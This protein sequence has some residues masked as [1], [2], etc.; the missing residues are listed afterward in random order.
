MSRWSRLSRAPLEKL[1]AYQRRMGWE[2]K[3]LSSLGSDFNWDYF[4]SFTPEQQQQQEMYYNYRLGVFPATECPGI[5][6]FFKDENGDVFH[7][8]SAYARGLETFLGIYNLLDIVPNGRDE[9]GLQYPMA[10]VRHR[11][12]Y[13]DDSFVDPYA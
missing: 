6:S 1:A 11:D 10:W 5:S 13:E 4:V 7:T 8:Y 3:W 9:A 2:M 12:R